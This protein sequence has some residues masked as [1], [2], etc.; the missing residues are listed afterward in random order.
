MFAVQV[1]EPITNL[2]FK[3]ENLEKKLALENIEL[4]YGGANVGL[5]GAVANGTLE[6]SGKSNRC[7]A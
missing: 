5:M 3:R 1:L 2:N 6:S 4:V 7:F